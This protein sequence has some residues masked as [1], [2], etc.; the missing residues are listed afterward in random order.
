MLIMFKV[1]NFGSFRDEATL[2]MRAVKAYKEHP[3][4]LIQESDKSQIIKVAPIFGAN[5]CGKSTLVYAYYCFSNIVRW[6]LYKNDKHQSKSILEMHY[7][8][9]LFD[10]AC[11]SADTEFEVIVHV[12]TSEY[13]YGFSYNKD[14]ISSEW[15]YKKSLETNR[16]VVILER[17]I[18]SGIELGSSIKKS[19]EKY[20]HDIDNGVLALTF[21]SSLK[22]RTHVFKDTYESICDLLALP[23]SSSENLKENILE[24]YFREKF[25]EEG[26]KKKLLAFLHA[27]DVEIKDVSVEKHD[28]K[29]A[30]YTYHTCVNGILKRVPIEIESDGTIKAISIYSLFKTAAEEDLGL[31]IDELNTQL[32][33]LLMKY[34]IDL[35]YKESQH[36]Q[37]IF[38]THD[39][40]LLDKR[41]M[42]RDQV[43]FINKDNNG[44]SSL[45]S[46]A[47]FKIRND[48]SFEKEYLGGV[49]G[50][51]PILSDYSFE[52]A[53]NE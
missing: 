52:E 8:P 22:L 3:Y 23:A 37:L 16:Q 31:I 27:I 24:L 53:A 4:N 12:G 13:R 39:T 17:S 51:I 29:I 5:A 36:G 11:V 34:L 45:Y 43:W 44:A 38:T 30:V 32:H 6:S 9:F 40:T 50:A 35:F 14:R 28:D 47:D 18:E 2:D 21:F 42:R 49:F 41:F 1:K 25:S 15:L 20:L 26:E 7:K 46:L 48:E 10:D 33:P 19:V